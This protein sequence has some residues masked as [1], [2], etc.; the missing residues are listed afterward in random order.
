MAT[1]EKAPRIDIESIIRSKNKNLLRVLPGFVLRY[2][3]KI[4][5]QDEVNAFLELHHRENG[6][7]FVRSV[8]NEFGVRVKSTGLQNI[9]KTGGCV[10][11]SNHPLGGLDALPLMNEVSTV[12]VDMKFL[13][14]DLLMS[15]ENLRSLFV[16]INKHG[17]NAFENI[18]R[19]AATYASENCTLIFPAGLVSRKQDGV[20]KDLD[21]HKSFITQAVKHKRNIIPVYIDAHNSAFFYNLSL[22]RK[23]LG[24]KAN[25][26]MFYLVDEMY[27]QRNKTINII[28]GEEI[29]YTTFTK[30][31]PDRH[32]AKV[33]RERVYSLKQL[34]KPNV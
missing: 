12:R 13:V 14:N 3:K 4:I 9:P 8:I 29:A 33:V 2:I 26:E 1:D 24:I 16:P 19:I 34:S 15:M 18:Q 5:H 22:W 27:K 10:I 25:I 6:L 28:V 23:R 31:H 30:D 7:E 21:W 20:I 17:K 11:V 32:W